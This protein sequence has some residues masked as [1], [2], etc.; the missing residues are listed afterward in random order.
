MIYGLG[1]GIPLNL[2]ALVPGG[3]FDLATRY[4]F[5]PVL[6]LGYIGLFAWVLHKKMVPW[7]MKRFEAIGK[8]ALS[9]Y[10]LQNIVAS[11]IFFM[12]GASILLPFL[13]SMLCFYVGCS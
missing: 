7:I 3:Y 11:L 13:L 10:I 6:A 2:L 9:C 4:I 1:I 12:V 5:A 8:T